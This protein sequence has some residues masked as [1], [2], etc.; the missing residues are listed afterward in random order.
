[1][2]KNLHPI[3][4]KKYLV[5]A[6]FISLAAF[7]NAQNL[8]KGKVTD[9]KDEALIGAA[10]LEKGT[11]NG[12]STDFDGNFEIKISKFPALLEVTYIGY[13]KKEIAVASAKEKLTIKMADDA[14][15]LVDVQ[16]KGQRISDK[17]KE[18]PLTIE[19]IDVLAI[20]ET[21][22]A[23]F[24]DGLGALKGVDLTAASLG[25]KIINTRGFN[26]TSPV[27]SLQIIDGVDN[28]SPGLNFS[29]GNFLGTS[30]LDVIKADIIVGASSAFYGP[31]AFNGVISMETKNPFY[32]KG[33]GVMLKGGER[34]LFEG[35]IR[36]ADAIKNKKGLD[37]FAYKLNFSYLR[38]DD[39]RAENYDPVFGSKSAKNNPGGFD[40][41]NVYGDEFSATLDYSQDLLRPNSGIGT[42]HRTGYKETDLVDYNTRNIKAN[43]AFHLRTSPSLKDESPELIYSFSLGNGTTVYQGDNR[44]SLK[45]IL[46]FQNR[47]EFRKRDKFFIRAYATNEDAGN[48]YDPYFTALLLQGKSKASDRWGS[49]YLKYWNSNVLDKMKEAGYP[50]LKIFIDPVTGIVSTT[51]DSTAAYKWLG[52]NTAFLSE[53]HSNA[54]ALSDTSKSIVGTGVAYYQPGT[55]RFTDE[56]NR[57][58]STKSNKRDANAGSRFFDKSALYHLHG[59]YKFAPTWAEALTVGANGRLYRPNSDGTIFKDT[60]GVVLS[61]FEYGIYGG[62]EKRFLDKQLKATLSARMDKNQNFNYLFSPAASLVWQP[63]KVDVVR[64]SFSSAIRNPTLTDQY[65]FL[66]VGPAILA[67]NLTGVD[68]LITVQSFRDYLDLKNLKNLKYFNIGAVRPEKVKTFELGYRT[69]FFEQLFMDASY[70]FSIYNDFLGYQIGIS[71]QFDQVT[72]LPQN[73]QA[74][75][76]AANSSNTV[77]TQGFSI[78]LNYFFSKYYQVSGNYSW[79]KLNKTFADDPI[80]PAFNTPEHKFNLGLSGRDVVVKLG[81][82]KIENVGFSM[83]YKFVKGFLFEGSPQFSGFIRD[84]G[85]LDAQVSLGVPKINTIFKLGAA[86]LLENKHYETY[87]GPLIGRLIYFSMVYDF[88]KK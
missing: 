37:V 70:Y 34:R 46:F 40:K 11:T 76:Y 69:T 2:Q 49:D 64:L 57:I 51:F 74:Y 75:R 1:M 55:Q 7:L 19:S 53:Y 60:A 84:Y 68:S 17:Q 82:K 35:A 28:Q 54:R 13:S 16:I 81:S 26:S 59:E 3:W 24:Y 8:L 78:G 32:Q 71:S 88:K 86:N 39:W 65:L 56:F 85:L 12:V 15:I 48:S 9:D 80:I 10:I 25:F 33:L 21:P 63:N 77:T 5:V 18:A 73:T 50:Q 36:W 52:D 29:L 20:K 47:V 22:A 41:V 30:E 4:G 6:V 79:N 38:A 31:N 87:G 61:N 72:G 43:A 83:N 45:D 58:T 62:V 44:F 66:N 14:V 67:G 27:R 42:L 23:N